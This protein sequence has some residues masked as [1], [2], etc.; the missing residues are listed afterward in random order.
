[1]FSDF[2]DSV[3]D[4]IRR[5]DRTNL[6][7]SLFDALR[8]TEVT[9]PAYSS[10]VPG[11]LRTIADQVGAEHLGATL[12]RVA[13]RPNP[14]HLAG[15]PWQ[16]LLERERCLALGLPGP[17]REA[18]SWTLDFVGRVLQ[19]CRADGSIFPCS[20]TGWHMR[21]L[22]E[23]NV[24]GLHTRTR[25]LTSELASRLRRLSASLELYSFLLHGEH[26]DGSFDHGPYPVG[27]GRVMVVRDFTDLQSQ[28]LP[29]STP[30]VR[31]SQPAISIALVLPETCIPEFNWA[32]T[33]TCATDVYEHF[34]AAA[35]FG[36][37][38][39]RLEPLVDAGD[40]D[41][42]ERE[43]RVAQRKLFVSAA[44]WPADEKIKYGSWLFTNH[45]QEIPRVLGLDRTVL[46][47]LG[48]P[49]TALVNQEFQRLDFGQVSPVWAALKRPQPFT[50]MEG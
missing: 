40:W 15:A 24:R 25:T 28:Y 38:N 31:L 42:L 26:R 4:F 35:I 13:R 7:V 41:K 44:A 46:E 6:K 34:E 5:A 48:A 17:P 30:E 49:F 37:S 9:L 50:P 39:G 19:A 21:I 22:D 32:G 29:W 20:R 36:V 23:A 14:M 18:I 43:A 16:C 2:S 12:R 8:R 47:Q 10:T 1:V 3:A 45:L 33:M 27:G 11:F